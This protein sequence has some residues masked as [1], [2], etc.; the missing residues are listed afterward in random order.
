MT[1]ATRRA[2]PVALLLSLLCLTAQA[3]PELL[4]PPDIHP[5]TCCLVKSGSAVFFLTVDTTT[6]LRAL[7][8]SDGTKEGSS[9]VKTFPPTPDFEV[10]N[11]YLTDVAGTLFILLT[12]VTRTQTELWKSDGT[13]AGTVRLKTLPGQ[14]KHDS[15]DGDGVPWVTPMAVKGMLFFFL[16]D[17]YGRNMELWRSD[18]TEAGTVRL[19]GEF[20]EDS[21][22]RSMSCTAAKG[23]F[24]FLFEPASI[25]SG[26]QLWKSDGTEEGTVLVRES[27]KPRLPTGSSLVA[28][29]STLY[30]V[31]E[32]E[33]PGTFGPW[34]WRSDGTEAGTVELPVDA[35]TWKSSIR[36]QPGDTGILYATTANEL[37]KTDGSQAG[38][39][40]L[41][42]LPESISHLYR[43]ERGYFIT[44]E[45]ELWTSDGTVEG[46]RLIKQ[47]F[48]HGPQR[49]KEVNGTLYFQASLEGN[50]LEWWKSDGTAEGTRPIAV[51]ASDYRAPSLSFPE[52]VN[53]RLLFF[54]FGSDGR[55]AL[56][57][58][59][60][61]PVTCPPAQVLEATG[62]NGVTSVTWPPALVADD[63]S[64]PPQVQYSVAS[65]SPFPL[66]T[67]SVTVTA[68][69]AAYPRSSCTFTVRVQ[70]TTPPWLKCP[71]LPPVEPTSE[72]GAAVT[73]PALGVSDTVST[74]T[75]TYSHASGS[76]FPKG[77]T[78]VTVTATD[79]A[80]NA[81]QCIFRVLVQEPVQP[82]PATPAQGCG[83][84]AAGTSG[85]LAWLLLLGLRPLLARRPRASRADGSLLP[86]KGPR[87]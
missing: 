9:L 62:P 84:C 25:T 14:V 13:E 73:F 43:G 10:M 65:G 37:M 28:V 86:G 58:L 41:A 1:P 40:K 30:F 48:V 76:T 82:L 69:D 54:T 16:T 49:L 23:T 60:L 77:S 67:T 55:E 33:D 46:T 78:L 18:G 56:W 31:A 59:P 2:L 34:L 87:A 61:A 52:K 85:E 26:I 6:G 81:S 83:G 63:V 32:T 45:G 12:D 38:T 35:L 39:V 36:L 53:G 5:H 4:L 20:G 15:W 8:K 42:T 27:K 11:W 24:F 50:M 51:P 70:D 64:A 57:A 75:V 66:G 72:D 80:G 22:P 19:K 68:T 17:N 29:D 47:G 7:W 3:D 79:A 44:T 71:V 21:F 74:P